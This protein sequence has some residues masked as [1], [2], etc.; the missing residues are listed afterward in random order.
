MDNPQSKAAYDSLDGYS[1]TG[2][3]SELMLNKIYDWTAKGI[4]HIGGLILEPV[5]GL[6]RA[7]LSFIP[8][9]HSMF[10]YHSL[11]EL[12]DGVISKDGN[13]KLVFNGKKLTYCSG[14]QTVVAAC[15]VNN[16]YTANANAGK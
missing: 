6:P 5:E 1:H 2:Y 8:T 3:S 10:Y 11:K 9:A 16:E 14:S 7:V 15:K 4:L 12:N 13:S